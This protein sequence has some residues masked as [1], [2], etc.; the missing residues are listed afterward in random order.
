MEIISKWTLKSFLVNI[1]SLN[2]YMTERNK[3]KKGK[4]REETTQCKDERKQ[5]T[6]YI[7]KPYKGG[8]KCLSHS[9]RWRKAR[10]K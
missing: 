9:I 7:R 2:T 3:K 6:I 8:H 1:K 5:K 4:M 10:E